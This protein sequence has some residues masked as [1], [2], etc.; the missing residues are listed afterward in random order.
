MGWC[1]VAGLRK[2][3]SCTSTGDI[4]CSQ[5]TL[6]PTFYRG[7]SYRAHWCYTK[8]KQA[9]CTLFMASKSLICL[10]VPPTQVH[11]FNISAVTEPQT[12]TQLMLMS[13]PHTT[14]CCIYISLRYFSSPLPCREFYKTVKKRADAFFK[15][16]NIVMN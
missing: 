15:A 10:S 4:V 8:S 12:H 13:S 16:N 2:T 9:Y 11:A 14:L 7:S 3:S 5:C 6:C 1:Q